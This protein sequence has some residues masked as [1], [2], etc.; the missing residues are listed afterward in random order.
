MNKVIALAIAACA[1]SFATSTTIA[2][3]KKNMKKDGDNVFAKYDTNS[4]GTLEAD[5]IKALQE[6]FTKGDEALKAYDTNKDGKLDENEIAAI[7]PPEKGKK[8]KK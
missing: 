6:A 5:E 2:A 8:K 3:E 1:L 7:K 4:N